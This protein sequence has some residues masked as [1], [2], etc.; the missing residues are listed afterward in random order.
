[1]FADTRGTL[2]YPYSELIDT[3]KP[4]MFIAENVKGLVNHDNGATLTTMIQVFKSI[5][6]QVY[7]NVLNSWDYDVAQKR[8]RIFI[9]GIRN[10]LV[11][12]EKYNFKFPKPFEYKPVLKDALKNVP[13]SQGMTY[14]EKK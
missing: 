11:Q 8:Q 2:F 10:D 6:Y 9:V 13:E 5:G 12:K 3:I 4:K 1:G 7:W 14:S